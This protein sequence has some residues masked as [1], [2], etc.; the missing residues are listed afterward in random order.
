MKERG[1]LVTSALLA[2]ACFLSAR[3]ALAFS[4]SYTQTVT[5]GSEETTSKVTIN[6]T[7]LRIESTVDGGQEVILRNETGIYDYLPEDGIAMKLL[8]LEP[9]QQPIQG[10]NDYPAYLQAHHAE[11][12][13]AEPIHDRWCDLYQFTDAETQVKTVVWLERERKLPVKFDLISPR[14]KTTV[15]LADVDV[16]AKPGNAAFQ[17]PF[18]IQFLDMESTVNTEPSL[19][20]A[21]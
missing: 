12:V 10:L 6:D 19:S 14:S 9:S 20:E 7:L 3:D 11:R 17:L 15:E 21:P 2:C 13:G 8:S 16:S 5:Q 4:I 18:D 1:R